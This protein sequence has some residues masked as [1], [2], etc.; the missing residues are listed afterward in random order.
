MV[1]RT[2]PLP[3]LWVGIWLPLLPLEALVCEAGRPAVAVI[4]QDSQSL[5]YACNAPARRAGVYAGMGLNGARALLP[6]LN[7]YA[8]DTVAEQNALRVLANWALSFTPVVS[9]VPDG[10]LLLE[11]GASLRLFGGMERLRG[12]LYS[13]LRQRVQQAWLACAPD[14]RAALWLAQAGREAC[15]MDRPAARHA[16][17]QLPLTVTRWPLTVQRQLQQMGVRTLGDCIRL[18]RAGFARRIGP[19]YLRQLDQACGQ[20]PDI[21]PAYRPPEV[22][23]D[24]LEC[25]AGLTDT[26]SLLQGFASLITS[27][28][29]FLVQRQL[30]VQQLQ[31][32]FEHDGRAATGFSL[33]LR[34]PGDVSVHVQELL[35]LR[36]ERERLS[37]PVT[38]IVLEATALVPGVPVSADL[39]GMA[40]AGS[41]VIGREAMQ[42]LDRL[43][44]RLGADRVYGVELV[45]E[46]RPERAWRKMT[47]IGCS[48]AAEVPGSLCCRPRP[49][50]LLSKPR[51]LARPQQSGLPAML[52]PPERI[53]SGWWDGHDIRRDYYTLTLPQGQRWWVFH[54]CRGTGW[55][56]HGVFG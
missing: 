46:H 33:G 19:D 27:L 25:V 55:Y 4:E 26:A 10:G 43:R 7:V 14:A 52:G 11:V 13:D 3:V 31:L 5:V 39:P 41:V 29:A 1:C 32:R 6:E 2:A 48:T 56:L 51:P 8:R 38:A 23:Q 21:R 44:T 42:L 36:L 16:L 34:E 20:Q 49:L 28:T 35:R 30:H 47:D 22:F 9:L 18:P 45:A 15:C 40:A 53:E 17:A 37:A 50:W 24:R 54:D 12:R